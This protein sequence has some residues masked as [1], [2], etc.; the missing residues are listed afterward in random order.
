MTAVVGGVTAP[1]GFLASGVPCGI[2]RRGK[3]LALIISK[4]PAAAAGALTQNEVKASCVDW[5]RKVLEGGRARALLANSGNA[6]CCT[7]RRGE[8]DTR[9]MARLLAQKLG[10]PSDQILVASTGIIGQFLPMERVKKGIGQAV[11]RL[12][13][14]GSHTAAEAI[15]TT[16]TRPKELAVRFRAGNRWVTIGGIAKGSGM[17][18]PHMATM[19]AFLTTD[20]DISL[21]ALRS[22]LRICVGETFNAITVDGEMSTNDMVLLLAN[23]AA[24]NL[25]IVGPTG[26]SYQAFLA[27]LKKVC[28]YLAH[29]I[30]R[31][32]EGV[33]RLM[34][35]RVTGASSLEAAAKVARQVAQSLLVKTMVA[36]RD[37]NWGRIASAAGASGVPVKPGKLTIRLGKRTVFR[38]GEPIR[39]PREE[40]LETVDPPEVQIGI[41]LA[42]GRHS[43]EI[44]S[45]DLTEGYIRINA[46]YTT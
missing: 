10:I 14:H 5:A 30:V 29:E 35:V 13:L 3:D 1:Q 24:G 12:T 39:L 18:S 32:G 28:R 40:L 43:A 34:R 38:W 20:A 22:A 4:K 46:K 23:G 25:R 36:G 17:V 11:R 16:D 42:S 37:P 2:K 26:T 15:L 8:R 9:S 44:L 31:D 27:A 19:L 21:A 33:T 41:D 45:G 7:G 6:N